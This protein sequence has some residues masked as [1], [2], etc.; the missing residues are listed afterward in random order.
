MQISEA[1]KEIQLRYEDSVCI[2]ILDMLHW[3]YRFGI[4]K[5]IGPCIL[6]DSLFFTSIG[7][8]MPKGDLQVGAEKNIIMQEVR[9]TVM[10][11]ILVTV[12]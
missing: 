3:V 6:N 8:K 2:Y 4:L 1:Q 10:S 5:N 12:E 11:I 9:H 7:H